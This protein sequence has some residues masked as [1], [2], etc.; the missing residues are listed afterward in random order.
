M[1]IL[2]SGASGLIGST[3]V[4]ELTRRGH[5]VAKLGRGDARKENE[6]SWDPERGAIDERSL[7]GRDVVVH[8]AG[9]NVAGRWTDEKKRRIRDSRVKSTRLLAEKLAPLEVKPSALVC[10]SAIGYY[11]DRGD[12]TLRED[13]APGDDFLAGVCREWEAAA[14]A[15][16]QAGIR[17]VHLRFGVVLSA[18]GGALAKLLTPFRF[19][20]GGKIGSGEQWMSWVAIDD[21]VGAILRALNRLEGPVNVVAPHPVTNLEFTETL[22]RVLSRPTLFGVPTFAARLAFGEMADAVLL[23]SAKVLPARLQQDGYEFVHPE[24]EAA[25]RYLLKD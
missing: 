11:G 10:A 19:G 9:E 12:E 13:S 8:L 25:L 16:R 24:L 21:A 18:R 17:V 1:N 5:V 7:A 3:F 23:S 20:V 15:A 4:P 22:G 2:V 14:D 6:F